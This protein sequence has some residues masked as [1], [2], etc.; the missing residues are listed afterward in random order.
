MNAGLEERV[1]F[2]EAILSFK[3]RGSLV[4]WLV[5]KDMSKGLG[6]SKFQKKLLFYSKG[7]ERIL[8]ADIQER[9]AALVFLCVSRYLKSR[10]VISSHFL[11]NTALPI[12]LI[13]GCCGIFYMLHS[14]LIPFVVE[15]DANDLQGG[16]LKF[17]Q[18]TSWIEQNYFALS[19]G[20]VSYLAVILS[21]MPFA[22]GWVR[23]QIMDRI[24]LSYRLY[25]LNVAFAFYSTIIETLRVGGEINK[26]T[27][28]DMAKGQSRY[29]RQS[30][31][32]LNAA[33]AQHKFDFAI[34]AANPSWPDPELNMMFSRLG[35]KKDGLEPFVEFF[36]DWQKRVQERI[37]DVAKTINTIALIG[38]GISIIFIMG[39]IDQI[40]SSVA[41]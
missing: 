31:K 1:A 9:G 19:V 21:L 20:W 37:G 33:M 14:M 26:S 17:Y 8:F 35:G 13:L 41:Y 16:L 34:I 22:S 28:E 27:L 25:K 11:R 38:I 10:N 4:S 7:G 6:S 40:V 29:V 5:A 39:T 3:R 18:I 24:F 32:R 15:R 2:D 12:V 30:I 23:H 36:E